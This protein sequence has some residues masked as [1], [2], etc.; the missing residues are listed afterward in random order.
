MDPSIHLKK[1]GESNL[2]FH[3]NF[4]VKGKKKKKKKNG[5]KI[6]SFIQGFI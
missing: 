5:K 4:E 1:K 6:S 2:C 3:K